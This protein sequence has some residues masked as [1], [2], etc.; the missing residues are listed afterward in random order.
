MGPAVRAGCIYFLAVFAFGFLLGVLRVFF[1]APA[2]GELG[3]VALELPIML[4]VSWFIC[5]KLITRF[6]VP[7]NLRLRLVMGG[8]AFALL[9]IA[10]I[11]VSIFAFGRTLSDHFAVYQRF[12]AQLGLVAQIIFAMFP[13]IQV[14]KHK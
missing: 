4:A 10:E 9:M 7:Y 13:A 2:I 8:A 5:G 1:L 11:S 14:R 3:A 6:S 12:P